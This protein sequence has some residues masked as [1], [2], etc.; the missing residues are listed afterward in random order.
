MKKLLFLLSIFAIV[1][2]CSSDETS[3]PV[4]P[5]P[6]PIA[7]YTITLSAGEGG[8]VSTTG[9]EYEAGQTVSVTATPQGEYL[10]KDWSDGN[11]NATRTITVSSNSTLTANFEKRKYPLTVNFDGEGEVIEEIVNSGRT[12]EYDSGTTVKLTAQAA[13]EWVFIGWTGDIESTEESVQIVIGEPKEVTATFEKKKYPLTV[14]IDGEGEV[15]EEIVNAGRTTDYDS[16]TTVKLT[17]VPA[18]GWRFKRWSNENYNSQ[19]EILLNSNIEL[20]A[21][22]E[23]LSEELISFYDENGGRENFHPY[24]VLALE[25]LLFTQKDIEND[26]L[27]EAKKRIDFVFSI[28]PRSDN[29]W[30]QIQFQTESTNSHCT[31]CPIN[32]GGPVSYYGLR[33]LEQIISNDNPSIDKSLELTVVVASCAKVTR[34]TLPNLSPETV[35]LNISEKILENNNYR[36]KIS[37]KLFRQWIKSITGGYNVNLNIH[38]VDECVEVNYSDDGEI[39]RS[40]VVNPSKLIDKVPI[41]LAEKTDFWWTVVPS[42]V[43]GDGTGFNRHFIT[44]GMGGYKRYG[45]SRYN[46]PHMFSDDAWFI[47]KPEHMGLGNYHE[48]ELKAY[49]PQYFQHEFMHYFYAI[50]SEF[51]LEKTSH[52]WFDRS[53]WPNDFEGVFE[54]DYYFESIQKR[55]INASPSLAYGL[56]FPGS[57]KTS[58]IDPYQYNLESYD[59]LIGFY[60]RE[61][62]QNDWHKVE[63]IETNGKLR[64]RNAAG[65][66][67]SLEIKEGELWTGPDCVYGEQKLGVYIENDGGILGLIFQNEVYERVS[68]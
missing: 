46:R 68:N 31:A 24:Q 49:Q 30:N 16:G 3:T 38:I 17:A 53:K 28:M 40:Y 37:S 18:E 64:W 20:I 43:P 25:T 61:P 56:E 59:S 45:D 57:P 1:L 10:F 67:W 14:N 60:E 36:L 66:T 6:A 7:K 11:T 4:T 9:G 52:Q 19:I 33:M 50:W 13:A 21:E 63:I 2:S 48:I 62:I 26:N 5:P 15:L 34:P 29:I 41:E 22:F 55:L 42:G 8:T 47:R 51:G 12:T 58:L 54:P 32:I 44:G 23:E 39:I 65:V 35:E 27:S